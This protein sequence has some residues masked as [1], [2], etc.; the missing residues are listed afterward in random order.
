MLK[1][2]PVK[3]GA[4]NAISDLVA[5]RVLKLV[6]VYFQCYTGSYIALPLISIYRASVAYVRGIK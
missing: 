2:Y 4:A 3:T 6:L 5:N 1:L